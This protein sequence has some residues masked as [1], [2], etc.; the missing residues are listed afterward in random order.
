MARPYTMPDPKDR[1]MNE[2]TKVVTPKQVVGYYNTHN[3]DDQRE[4]VVDAVKDFYTQ[5]AKKAGW[6]E[7]TFSG[8]QCILTAKVKVEE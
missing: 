2:P 3:K 8:G 5:E 6:G 7:V 1:S 4:R